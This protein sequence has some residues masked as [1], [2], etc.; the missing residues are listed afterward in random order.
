[1]DE[2]SLEGSEG[3]CGLVLPGP[4]M[5]ST[6]T[7]RARSASA[8]SERW[9]RHGTASA[10]ITATGPARARAES[11]RRPSANSGVPM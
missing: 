3:V 7:P 5:C 2:A 4:V 11:S 9:Q 8:S 10:H 6:A 1:M